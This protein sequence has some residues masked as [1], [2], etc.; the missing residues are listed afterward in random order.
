MTIL[1][2]FDPEHNLCPVSIKLPTFNNS[3]IPILTLTHKKNHFD[4]SFI[5]V[6]S[7]SIPIL[8]LSTSESLNLI[9]FISVVNINNKQFL[10]EFPD[11]FGEIGSLKNTDH[12][13]IKD[14]VAPLVTPAR[15]IPLTLKAKLEQELKHM[16]DLNI[17]KPVPKPTD[18]VNKLILVKF[19]YISTQDF[20]Q[21][22]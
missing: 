21:S 11:F 2:K 7:K 1:K 18:W 8:R 10:C 6:D 16:V 15:K 14:N 9:K 5:L 17:I 22:H 4:I 12:F 19:G 3:K 20:E 13:E